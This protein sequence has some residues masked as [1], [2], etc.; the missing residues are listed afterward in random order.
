MK[1]QPKTKEIMIYEQ[2]INKNTFLSIRIYK[3]IPID[4]TKQQLKTHGLLFLIIG[5]SFLMS[6]Q[7]LNKFYQE[8]LIYYFI[9]AT[10]FLTQGI[11]Y[12][13]KFF[14]NF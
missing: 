5:M 6:Y 12:L 4:R 8:N 13:H 9:L 11:N 14:F 3:K 1:K 7:M 2:R 10:A